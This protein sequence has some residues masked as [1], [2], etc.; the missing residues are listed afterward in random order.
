MVQIVLG[1]Q[2]HLGLFVDEF[3]R[4]VTNR[5]ASVT[6]MDMG[7]AHRESWIGRYQISITRGCFLCNF[8]PLLFLGQRF[9]TIHTYQS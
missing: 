5:Q 9:I 2:V 6:V 3:G 1:H 7:D 4:R 8:E